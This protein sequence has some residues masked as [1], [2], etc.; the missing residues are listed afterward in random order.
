MFTEK[1]YYSDSFLTSCTA[2]VVKVDGPK[3]Y[4][5][6]TVAYPEGGGQISDT[7]SLR[8][9]GMVVPFNDVQKGLG[10][11]FLSQDF[12]VINVNTPIYH[13]IEEAD[14]IHFSL[15]SEVEV[16][17]DVNRRIMTTVHHS[18]IHLALMFAS[19][20]RDSLTSRIRGCSITQESAR[21]DFS[22]PE[23]F[24]EADIKYISD[25]IKSIVDADGEIITYQHNQEPEAW[26]WKYSDF[27]CPC[28]GTHVQRT[29]QIGNVNVRR[30]GIGKGQ[31]RLIVE[32]TN[33]NLSESNYH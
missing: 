18:A 29:G 17:I 33:P 30:R 19:K 25:S 14:I 7:G 20:I 3:I 28:G 15:D 24:T 26:F 21:L 13:V 10:K 6:K 11:P 22:L 8:V 27:I 4:L 12:P 5:D 23:R 31:E 16:S 1:L 9:N 32:V 2:K